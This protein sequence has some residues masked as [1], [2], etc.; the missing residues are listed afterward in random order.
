[1]IIRA[2]TGTHDWQFGKGK[3][4]YLRN[5]QAIML[6]VKTRLLS[7]YQDC[8]FDSE[9]GIDWINLMSNRST[10]QEIILN[11]R[12]VILQSY[13]IVKV[14][15]IDVLEITNRRI[16]LTYNA[17]TIFTRRISSTVEVS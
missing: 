10:Q 4:S 9:F 16:Q 15:S 11:C 7:F 13:G 14:N 6:N 8:F 17:D 5:D 12:G 1:M 2:L 3:E